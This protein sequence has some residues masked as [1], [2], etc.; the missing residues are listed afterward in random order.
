MVVVV[1][2]VVLLTIGGG[3]GGVVVWTVF[4]ST[5]PLLSLYVVFAESVCD[6]SGPIVLRV[7]DVLSVPGGGGTIVLGG[8]ATTTGGAAGA[9][10]MIVVVCANAAL[11][12]NASTTAPAINTLFM[13]WLQHQKT[14]LGAQTVL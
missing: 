7:S 10:V 4:C 9:G 2:V 1:R 13:L 3:G 8:G 5:T 11:V 6:P 14:G 12:L